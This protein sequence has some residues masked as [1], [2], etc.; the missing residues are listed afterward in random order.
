M[1]QENAM[2]CIVLYRDEQGRLPTV[3]EMLRWGFSVSLAVTD[4]GDAVEQRASILRA[5]ENPADYGAGCLPAQAIARGET[6]KK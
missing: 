3:R 2:R 4:G 6:T 5:A 1:H